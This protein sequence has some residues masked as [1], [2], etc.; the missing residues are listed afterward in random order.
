MK[1]QFSK[2]QWALFL[3]WEGYDSYLSGMEK[4]WM[5]WHGLQD[6]AGIQLSLVHTQI[7]HD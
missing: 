5:Y 6:G 7:K 3:E 4:E 2:V 1:E